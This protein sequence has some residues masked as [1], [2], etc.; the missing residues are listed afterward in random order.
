MGY[1]HHDALE[2]NLAAAEALFRR[3]LALAEGCLPRCVEF[4]K[5]EARSTCAMKD[6]IA[7]LVAASRRKKG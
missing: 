3:A 2:R 6:D 4:L 5:K 7:E 1:F